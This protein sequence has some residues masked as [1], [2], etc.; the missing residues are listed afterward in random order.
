MSSDKEIL[1]AIKELSSQITKLNSKIDESEILNK[2][3]Q[4]MQWKEIN[5][6]MDVFLNLSK[7]SVDA[8]VNEPTTT[9]KTNKPTFFKN[10]FINEYDKYL[11]DLYTQEEVDILKNHEDVKK[12]V[13][14]ADK[15]VKIASLIYNTHI[16]SNNPEGR[17]AKFESIYSSE[18]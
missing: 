18:N 7:Q 14:D 9:R 11:N 12:K 15:Q 2:T 16:K 6:K 13:K 5:Y 17:L 10:L 8:V 4:Q 1:K 3:M